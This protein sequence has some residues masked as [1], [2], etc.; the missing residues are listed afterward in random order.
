MIRLFGHYL[1]RSILLLAVIE[2]CVL[3]VT[4]YAALEV[5]LSLAGL[6]SRGF[7]DPAANLA[8]FVVTL[9]LVMLALGL[10]QRETCRDF[11]NTVFTLLA[12]FLVAA[13][14]LAL[15]FYLVPS[16]AIWRSIFVIALFMAFIGIL[17]VR[18]LFITLVDLERFK[19]RVLVLGAGGLAAKIAALDDD[20]RVQGFICVGF[21]RMGETEQDIADCIERADID[22]LRDYAA[23]NDVDEIVT[24]MSERRANMPLRELLNCR[25]AGVRISDYSGFIEREAGMVDLDGFVPSWLI[26]SEGSTAGPARLFVKRAIDLGSSL[27]LLVL[28]APIMLITALA[29]AVTS[30]GPVLYRQERVGQG[31]KTFTL[32]KFRSM[33]ADA[34]SDSGPQWADQNDPRVT[35]VGRVIRKLRIDE[36]PQ[37]IN[38]LKGDMS[39]VGPRPERPFFVEEIAREVP[40]FLERHAVRPGITGWAQ[41][42][43]P[44]G[45]TIEDAKQKVQFDLYYIKNFSVF[46]DILTLIRTIRVVLF[47][48]G[49]R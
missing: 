13:L 15:I 29:I 19:R 24:A 45:A 20:S 7:T 34:E 22:S 36:L 42:N 40:Y 35:A 38:V 17:T 46:L 25:L 12:A 30:P 21:V 1:L 44:Y 6:S 18:V 23:E 14:I 48:A 28:T 43:Y 31:G 4:A 33:R 49:A 9:Q 2:T 5:R 26:Y 16:I 27:I 41:V 47:S 10:Y 37:I 39:F 32:N 8:I 11:R 3:V